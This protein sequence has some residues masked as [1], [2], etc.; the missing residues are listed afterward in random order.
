MLQ[1]L[2]IKLQ[3]LECIT[4]AYMFHIGVLT[5]INRRNIEDLGVINTHTHTHTHNYKLNHAQ[6]AIE[7]SQWVGKFISKGC[8]FRWASA[9]VGVLQGNKVNL[10]AMARWR[11]STRDSLLNQGHWWEPK[12]SKSI[13]NTDS[14]VGKNSNHLWWEAP[15]SLGPKHFHRLNS[16]SNVPNT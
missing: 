15:P 9:H 1:I 3:Y 10:G 16:K 13:V 6:A 7:G 12:Y 2:P 11:G 5:R 8:F 4:M 14:I